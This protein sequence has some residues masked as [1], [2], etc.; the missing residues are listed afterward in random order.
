MPDLFTTRFSLH[1]HTQSAVS[2]ARALAPRLRERASDAEKQ[3][4]VHAESISE[5]RE[6]GLFRLMQPT[7][8]DGFGREFADYVL[9]VEE[10]AAGCPSAAWIYAN[11]ILKSWM[12]GMFP[13]EAQSDFWG[14]NKD[15][16]ASSILRPTGRSRPVAGGYRLSGK[17][18][19]VSGVDHTGWTI[20]G[21][22]RDVKNGSLEP[23]VHLVPREDYEIDDNWHV[24]GLAA[25][26]SKDI[27]LND[28]FVPEHRTMSIA[29]LQ[30]CNPPGADLHSNNPVF[31]VPLMSSFGLFISAPILGI[32]TGALR[33]FMETIEA[34]ST[35]GGAAGGG[36]PMGELPT[37]QLRLVESQM[38]IEAARATMLDSA[39]ATIN[40]A[41][42]TGRVSDEQRIANRRAQSYSARIAVEAVDI[43][44]EAVGAAGLFMSQSLQRYWRDAHAG[45]AHFG[46][47]WDAIRLMCGQYAAGQTPTL[48]YY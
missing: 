25:S 29:Q 35:M 10:L 24:I 13:E 37:I 2:A 46:I 43:M 28:V 21:S 18:S 36:M 1:P 39:V 32:A 38:R 12:I 3:R 33:L 6:A 22:L 27:R 44:F 4:M 30:S 19:Y 17:W 48:K 45:A 16:I 15:S 5:M 31:H 40:E 34:R 11:V 14:K 42:N 7:A 9:V 26:G 20:I 47:N 23:I 41:K 8:Y